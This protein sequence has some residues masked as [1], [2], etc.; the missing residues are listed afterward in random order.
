LLHELGIGT[1][2][3]NTASEDRRSELAVDF[4]G[5][6]ILKFSIQDKLVAI[7]T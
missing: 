4:F 1:V 2:V 5:V 3:D 6:D 7:D